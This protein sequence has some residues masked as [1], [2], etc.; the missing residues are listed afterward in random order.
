MALDPNYP[1]KRLERI[2]TAACGECPLYQP[3]GFHG[4]TP[5]FCKGFTPHRPIADQYPFPEWCPLK[6]GAIKVVLLS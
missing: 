2:N 1:Y 5:D 3:E 4:V 6:G